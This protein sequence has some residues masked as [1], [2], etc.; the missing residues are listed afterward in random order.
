MSINI[1]DYVPW[2]Q[3][4]IDDLSLMQLFQ[5]QDHLGYVLLCF[6]LLQLSFPLDEP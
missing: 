1:K 3:I 2:L 6:V 4:P 5:G